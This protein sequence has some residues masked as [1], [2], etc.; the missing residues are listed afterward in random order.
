MLITGF[1]KSQN[2]LLN[3]INFEEVEEVKVEE[4]EEEA[5]R[6]WKENIEMT[7][8]RPLIVAFIH[9]P[10]KL[11]HII[12]SASCD[13]QSSYYEVKIDEIKHTLSIES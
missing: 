3:L 7:C 4:E 9:F 8:S 13:N 6:E 11:K 5:E 10:K 12:I 1:G 2:V